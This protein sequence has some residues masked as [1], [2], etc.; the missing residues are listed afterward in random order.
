MK[1]EIMTFLSGITSFLL[2]LYNTFVVPAVARKSLEKQRQL[3]P[4]G[5]FDT[6]MQMAF[7]NGISAY[8]SFVNTLMNFFIVIVVFIISE[9]K[10]NT[11][12]EMISFVSYVFAMVVYILSALTFIAHRDIHSLGSD[13]L[14]APV[15]PQIRISVERLIQLLAALTVLPQLIWV[16]LRIG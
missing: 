14:N 7:V 3:G 15:F 9:L 16:Y 4:E 2:V 6:E 12:L 11:Q 8:Q 1:P 5:V 10:N 13:T